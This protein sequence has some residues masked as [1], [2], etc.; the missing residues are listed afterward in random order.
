MAE[1]LGK[2][3]DNPAGLTGRDSFNFMAFPPLTW[4]MRR[5]RPDLEAR[6]LVENVPDI[7]EPR[8]AATKK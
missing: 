3:A 4:L 5:A 1:G 2:K 6:V 8:R 7:G